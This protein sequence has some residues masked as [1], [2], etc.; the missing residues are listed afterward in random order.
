LEHLVHIIPLGWEHDRAVRPLEAMKVHKVYALVWASEP[1]REHYMGRF[2]NWAKKRGVELQVVEI[3]SFHNLSSVMRAVSRIIIDELAAGNRIYINV[4]TSGKVAAIGATLAAMAHLPPTR[5]MVYFVVALDY[6]KD[7]KTQSKHGV[8]RGMLGDPIPIPIF[9]LSLPDSDCRLVLT[10]LAAATKPLGYSELARKLGRAGV[11][12]FN[13]VDEAKQDRA[14][15]TRVQV[16][17]HRRIVA[18]LSML[19]LIVVQKSGRERMLSLT[20]AGSQFAALC[21]TAQPA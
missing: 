12:P 10:E 5:G 15:R 20:P 18:K 7:R 9:P 11:S 13:E 8:A 3:D 14:G 16:A 17:F 6:P 19:D 1:R 2:R 21:V 4:S